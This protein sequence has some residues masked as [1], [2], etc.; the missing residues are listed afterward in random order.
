MNVLR[1]F[2]HLL[3][4]L[5]PRPSYARNSGLGRSNF[6]LARAANSGAV[7]IK[8]GLPR[9]FREVLHL[10]RRS[11]EPRLQ[12]YE[13]GGLPACSHVV[14][15]RLPRRPAS[16]LSAPRGTSPGHRYSM[17]VARGWQAAS[18]PGL[19]SAKC[20]MIR[21]WRPV[22]QHTDVRF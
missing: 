4:D 12:A 15:L 16:G 18:R 19:A 6:F 9:R 1:C 3:A 21:V 10:V 8:A 14:P 2:V 22:R 20:L 5:A 17:P 11:L 7:L 13:C